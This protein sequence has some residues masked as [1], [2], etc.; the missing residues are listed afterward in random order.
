MSKVLV[1]AFLSHFGIG[2]KDLLLNRDKT[3]TRQRQVRDKLETRQ[4]QDRDKTET[5]Q[6]QDRDKTCY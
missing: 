4:R 1:I 5:R 2:F 6:R 3:E